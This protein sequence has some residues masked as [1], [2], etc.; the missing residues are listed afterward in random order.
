MKELHCKEPHRYLSLESRRKIP[1]FS[2][3][4]LI[5]FARKK[6]RQVFDDLPCSS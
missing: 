5:Y 4:P 2:T 1:F 3:I 6:A